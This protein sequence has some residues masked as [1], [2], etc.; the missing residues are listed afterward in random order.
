MSDFRPE[1]ILEVARRAGLPLKRIG[2][3]EFAVPCPQRHLHKNN[4]EH[5]SCRLN[6]EKGVFH[7]DVCGCGGGIIDFARMVGVD[8]SNLS[9]SSTPTASLPTAEKRGDRDREPLHFVSN[10]PISVATQ[11]K[12][13]EMLAKD[14]PPEVWAKVGVLEGSIKV[15][16]RSGTV[17]EFPAISFSLPNGGY[18][19]C[20]YTR[21]DPKRGKKYTFWYTD[22]GKPELL[23]FGEGSEVLVTA[24]EWD[25]M[26][27]LAI[28]IPCVATG[29]GGEGFWKQEWSKQLAEKRVLIAYDV[30]EG[31][32]RGS[33]KV[34]LSLAGGCEAYIVHLPLSGKEEE[35]GKDLSDFLAV[36]EVEQLRSVID[37]CIQKGPFVPPT[38][39]SPGATEGKS[40]EDC[41][42]EINQILQFVPDDADEVFKA[43]VFKR[44]LP[45]F[46]QLT[47]V[48]QDL[49]CRLASKKLGVGVRAI[50]E[51]IQ[52][53]G[54]GAKPTVTEEP[55][56]VE[57]PKES[58]ELLRDPNLLIRFLDDTTELGVVGEDYNKIS[59]LFIMTSR[60]LEKP[61][62]GVVKAES[63]AGK[64]HLVEAV[65][66]T[67]P[68]SQVI[69]TTALSPQ[70]LNYWEGGFRNKVLLIAE[71]AG[72]ERAEYSLRVLQSEG[73]LTVHY[74]TK[75]D[76]QL[77][78][79]EKTVEGPA[80]TIT[81]TTRESLHPENETRLVELTLD[82]SAEQTARITDLQARRKMEGTD[83][84]R[85]EAV[86]EIWRGAQ[87]ALEP[88]PVV[89]PFAH[90]I[91]FP[92]K[93]VRARRDFPKL[94]AL[95]EASALLHQ[96]QRDRT[97]RRGR[98]HI[99][100]DVRDYAIAYDLIHA[101]LER[102]QGGLSDRELK[103]L[104]VLEKD[105]GRHLTVRQIAEILGWYQEAGRKRAR[106]CLEKLHEKGLA[107][108]SDPKTGVATEYWF[109]E[110]PPRSESGIT[111]PDALANLFVAE[112][113]DLP[114]TWTSPL[115]RF[116]SK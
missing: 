109:R 55:M 108:A 4:D 27:A 36:H 9:T 23:V 34:A 102:V 48:N 85:E 115:S 10:G 3:H 79:I 42:R 26:A 18:K 61:L 78:T 72:A 96:L 92:T 68:P 60:L 95:V 22:R 17:Q 83:P 111:T 53:L 25:L 73:N 84:A 40:P 51:E 88:L 2:Q 66:R 64:N 39:A 37:E 52:R 5:P 35:D 86:V 15:N 41:F 93:Q 38:A 43:E 113:G 98:T 30:D 112:G 100:A 57:P 114:T 56:P 50:R 31:G 63:S 71:A 32:R 105:P 76:G 89:I 97:E 103:I 11:I 82:E 20:L 101:F 21:R 107:N 8:I 14:Y 87:I 33:E 29:T 24:G 58:I 59:L 65:A 12:V 46:S 47:P 94:L 28:G 75:H 99:V 16:S 81:T 7:C 69:R 1:L 104:E 110:P 54:L 90:L 77:T 70:A 49:A 106:R 13:K 19:V 6:G 116:N 80:A 67:L 62:N 91:H 44:L 74:V 45:L